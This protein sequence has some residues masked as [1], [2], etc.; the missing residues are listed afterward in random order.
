MNIPRKQLVLDDPWLESNEK[1]I[2]ERYDRFQEKLKSIQGNYGSLKN[3]SNQHLY[4]GFNYDPHKK[5]YTYREWAPEASKLELVGDFNNWD[6]SDHTLT[7]NSEGIWEIVFNENEY[8]RKHTTS[9]CKVRVYSKNGTLDRIPAYTLET[10]QNKTD[11]SFSC[12]IRKERGDF[13]WSKSKVTNEHLTKPVIYECHVGMALEEEKVSSFKEFT[14]LILPRIHRNGYNTIQLMAVQEHPYYGSFGYHVSNFYAV[15]SRFGDLN[16]LK[17]L[18]NEAHKLGIAVVMDIV[19]SHSV[20]NWAE[21]LGNFDGSGHQYFHEGDRG[22]H[23]QWDSLIFNYGKD[24]VLQFLLSNLTY[25]LE[26]FHFDGFRFDGVTSMMYHHHGLDKFTSYDKYFKEGVEWD[27]ITYLQLATKLIKEINPKS[28]I[29][30]EDMSGMP[31]LCR[32]IED[33]GIGFDFRLGMGIPDYWIK[34]LKEQQDEEWDLNE[35]WGMLCNR[36]FTEKTI[37][38]A[39]SHDQSLV[40]DK[41]LAF[42]LM[43]KHMYFDMATHQENHIIDRGIALHKMIRLITATAGGEGYLTFIGNEFGHPEWMDFPREGNNWSFKHCKRQWSLVDNELLKY[44]FL[45]HFD[46]DLV[47][48][49]K[50][51]QF[52]SSSP[53]QLLTID[54]DRRM[55]VYEKGNYIFVLNWHASESY[56]DFIIPINRSGKFSVILDSDSKENGGFNRINKETEHFS[57]EQNGNHFLEIYSPSRTGLV[58]KNHDLD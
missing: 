45:N 51:E 46:N 24:E 57:F 3:F 35:L 23:P 39:E 10:H 26:E 19:H 55:I 7:K 11:H 20:K 56:S 52:L 53:A 16:D 22:L 6:G 4:L 36:R 54:T 9:K 13:K 43:D 31:G 50:T 40:G 15:A 58:F 8:F 48:F 38:Y 12:V 28:L 14:A 33:G 29:I 30:A 2:D 32:N 5:Q 25:W 34:L 27:A 1:E 37:S 17:H 49:L 18:I 44:K 21:G 42:W 47:H 41:T